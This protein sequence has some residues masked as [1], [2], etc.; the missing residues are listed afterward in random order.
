MTI[1]AEGMNKVNQPP[2]P[3]GLNNSTQWKLVGGK[4]SPRKTK[5]DA[6]SNADN[7]EK[8]TR[9]EGLKELGEEKMEED[10]ESEELSVRKIAVKLEFKIPKDARSFNCAAIHRKWAE[11]LMRIDE[12]TMIVTKNSKK[13]NEIK[14]FPRD[15]KTYNEEFPQRVTKQPG[16]ARVVEVVFELK[17]KK[18]F[19]ELKSNC[20]E[21]MEFLREHKTYFKKNI[22][23]QTRRDSIGFLTHIHPR[24]VWREE[25]Q[26]E[27]IKSVKQVMREEE[28]EK[29]ENAGEDGKGYYFTLNLRKLYANTAKGL[30]QT[31]IIEVQTAPELRETIAGAM[32]RA[33]KAKE[34][35]G[36]YIPYAIVKNTGKEE[37]AKI[38]Q[39]QN[40]YLQEI[41]K[42]EIQGVTQEMLEHRVKNGEEKKKI[43]ELIKVHPDIEAMVR[44]TRTEE[45]G[46][47]M[48]LYKKEN[49]ESANEYIKLVCERLNEPDIPEETRHKICTKVRQTNTAKLESMTREYTRE[50]TKTDA[51]ENL[52]SNPPNYWKRRAITLN[53]DP[54]EYP[55]LPKREKK[56]RNEENRHLSAED[57]EDSK[58][59]EENRGKT[60][61]KTEK[62][63]EER[64][65][66][67]EKRCKKLQDKL[68]EVL[69]MLKVFEKKQ[70]ET[71]TRQT[72]MI[73][74]QLILMRSEA[75]NFDMELRSE[76]N[77]ENMELTK[78]D[79]KRRAAKEQKEQATKKAA[80]SSSPTRDKTTR[81]KG[82]DPDI[83][84][85]E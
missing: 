12:E 9:D 42:I 75:K 58:N 7:G 5:G 63:L 51:K 44:T 68:T 23:N 52:P 20:A 48:F 84:S 6:K 33:S 74:E 57:V 69:E 53:N 17:T 31:E 45:T 8:A 36:E 71:A 43:G 46:T 40:K 56:A 61:K 37:F 3:N 82:S 83:G 54:S 11:L 16:Q 41:K 49:E 77:V 55:A 29:C 78:E 1:Y 19:N 72:E 27:L 30:T 38:L 4:K 60:E 81:R 79:N 35:K 59:C 24:Y 22:S 65:E 85:T 64:I 76:A 39:Q 28:I 10:E 34:M 18:R 32:I 15:Q 67:M 73:R 50:L 62:Q 80:L 21:M 66:K 25:L 2:D 26:K 13:I 70:E 47:Y 14:Q